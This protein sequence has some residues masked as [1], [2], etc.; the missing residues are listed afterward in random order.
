[1]YSGDFDSNNSSGWLAEK[2]NTEGFDLYIDLT[3]KRKWIL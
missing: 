2:L 1:M 3:E